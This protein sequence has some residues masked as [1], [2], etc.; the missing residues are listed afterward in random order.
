[1]ETKAFFSATHFKWICCCHFCWLHFAALSRMS[2]MFFTASSNVTA[3]VIRTKSSAYAI[4]L[5]NKEKFE[6]RKKTISIF[7]GK[8]ENT[9]PCGQPTDRREQIGIFQFCDCRLRFYS[10]FLPGT[11]GSLFLN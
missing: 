3:E 8:E 4:I 10:E 6:R 5:N 1:M 7:K 11:A 2:Y 9:H